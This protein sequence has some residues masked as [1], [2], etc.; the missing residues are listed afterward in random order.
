MMKIT[1]DVI[2]YIYIKNIVFKTFY[3]TRSDISHATLT[4]VLRHAIFMRNTFKKNKKDIARLW[5]YKMA[6]V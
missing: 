6:G 5:F 1:D 3:C 4:L 2:S